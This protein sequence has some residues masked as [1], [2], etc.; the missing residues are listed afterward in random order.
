MCSHSSFL[1]PF[2]QLL[3][4][5]LYP[6]SIL[7]PKTA[8][9]FDLLDTFH[10]LSMQAKLNLYDFYNVVMQKTDNSGRTKAKVC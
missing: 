7:R 9:T 6:A 10:K 4:F 2:R 8:F 1:E 3:R 5:R